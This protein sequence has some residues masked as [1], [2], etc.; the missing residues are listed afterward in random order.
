MGKNNLNFQYFGRSNILCFSVYMPE[1]ANNIWDSKRKQNFTKI[2]NAIEYSYSFMGVKSPI[3]NLATS[4]NFKISVALSYF[5]LK[6][7]LLF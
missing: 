4:V 2:T 7:Q 3:K 6:I 5:L 1:N